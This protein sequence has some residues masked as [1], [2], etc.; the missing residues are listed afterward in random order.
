MPVIARRK[1]PVT[2]DTLEWTGDN[3]EEVQDFVGLTPDCTQPGFAV[4]PDGTA[5]VWAD[6][7][8]CWVN[9]PVGHS[10]IHGAL[11]EFYPISPAA[12]ARTYD[13]ADDAL[14]ASEREGAQARE[15]Q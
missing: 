10:I 7:E 4:E 5:L 8:Q 12:L 15:Q 13:P 2:V 11:D 14:A 3:L 9:V 6:H 1:K